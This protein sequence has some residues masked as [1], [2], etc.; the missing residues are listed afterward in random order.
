[1]EFRIWRRQREVSLP[2]PSKTRRLFQI[3]SF[4]GAEQAAKFTYRVGDR[5]SSPLFE[6]DGSGGCP[7]SNWVSRT[8]GISLVD[9]T[10]FPHAE[11]SPEKISI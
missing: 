10:T 1:M 5:G 8:K 4:M 9:H 3:H 11:A 2:K 7:K 6:P